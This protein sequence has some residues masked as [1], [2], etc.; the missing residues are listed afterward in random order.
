MLHITGFL[1]LFFTL[2]G[3]CLNSLKQS[4]IASPLHKHVNIQF[5][6]FYKETF[7]N[8]QNSPFKYHK[9]FVIIFM[10]HPQINDVSV[11]V[12]ASEVQVLIRPITSS[13]YSCIGS[14]YSSQGGLIFSAKATP[15]A[16]SHRSS[17]IRNKLK[18][19]NPY[20]TL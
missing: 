6:V 11:D 1:K 20:F 15:K 12:Q 9:R 3:G 10:P 14:L 8:H 13:Y 17:N 19:A 7:Q 18:T 4:T 5:N 16:E 2:F